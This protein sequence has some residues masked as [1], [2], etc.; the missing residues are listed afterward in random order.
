M[1]GG[2]GIT[3]FIV[4]GD[5]TLFYYAQNLIL[6]PVA[7]VLA[8]GQVAVDGVAWCGLLDGQVGGDDGLTCAAVHVG[9]CE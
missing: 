6:V 2:A 4:T 9:G 1:H 7:D 8:A 5:E 3:I